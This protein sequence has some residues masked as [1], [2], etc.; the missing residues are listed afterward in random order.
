MLEADPDGQHASGTAPLAKVTEMFEGHPELPWMLAS[1]GVVRA[2]K[3]VMRRVS[4]VLKDVDDLS[5]PR[6]EIL[7]LLDRAEGG[8]LAVRDLKRESLLHPPSLTF[9]LDWLEERRLVRRSGNKA[10]RRS[11][12]ITITASGRRLFQRATKALSEIRFGLD[13]LDEK[14]ASEVAHVLSRIRGNPGD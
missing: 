7:G 11:V 2:Q 1:A 5:M 4:S 12:V 13:G 6:Y 8:H 10:D 9:I 14:T 3:I